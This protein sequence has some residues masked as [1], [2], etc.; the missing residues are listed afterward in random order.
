MYARTSTWTGS[1]DAL[2]KWVEHVEKSVAPM[3]A[4][5]AGNAGAF[6]FADRSGGRA[7]TLTLWDSEDA[8]AA[9][10]LTADQSRDRTVAATGVALEQRPGG[11]G[12]ARRRGVCGAFRRRAARGC[13]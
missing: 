6:F 11:R 9:T 12:C 13:G 10:D 4:G 5:L 1:A 7:L 2:E 3:I 8:A